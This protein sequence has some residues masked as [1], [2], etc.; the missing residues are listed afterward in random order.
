MVYGLQPFQLQNFTGLYEEVSTLAH[1]SGHSMHSYLS[2]EAQPYATHDYPIFMAEIASTVT[3]NFL[4]H[5][6]VKKAKTD[7]ERLFFLGSYL[8]NLRTTLFR[9]TLFAEFELTV[10]E[11][12]ESG[13]PLTADSLNALYL[14]L[15][16]DYYGHE[17]GVT[18]I[19][20]LYAA[21]WAY[22]PHFYYNFYVYQYATSVV[23]AVSIAD[24][25]RNE[26]GADDYLA[27]LSAGSSRYAFDLLKDAGVDM[28]T[29]KPFDAA[30]REMNRI[31]DEMEKILD[32]S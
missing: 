10:H 29:S 16:K 20:D 30:M 8:D 22:I 26:G 32:R 3:E 21:E 4:V 2:S 24:R 27:M 18:N 13:E 23:S 12:V 7:D 5:H 14:R 1:E 25:I 9:Q 19:D 28:T 15:L 11:M 17:A 6:M 31:M